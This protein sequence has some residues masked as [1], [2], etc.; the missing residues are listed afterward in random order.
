MNPLPRVGIPALCPLPSPIDGGAGSYVSS[1]PIMQLKELTVDQIRYDAWKVM[2][3]RGRI[4]RGAA[5]KRC[6]H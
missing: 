1:Q 2:I 6:S 4:R 5:V 3:E